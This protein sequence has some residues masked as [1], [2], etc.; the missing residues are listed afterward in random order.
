M[1]SKITLTVF[2]LGAI[3]H[4]DTAGAGVFGGHLA[5]AK[6]LP[7]PI[8]DTPEPA[9]NEATKADFI[10][11]WSRAG[12]ALAD[13]ASETIATTELVLESD[14]TLDEFDVEAQRADE[15][16][17]CGCCDDDESD[18]SMADEA[19]GEDESLEQDC[20]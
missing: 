11:A 4:I 10:A 12:T 3:A 8:S 6:S 15:D 20:H 17:G 18:P 16:Q 13:L 9:R 1:A 19:D 7:S 14:A 2:A 5:V